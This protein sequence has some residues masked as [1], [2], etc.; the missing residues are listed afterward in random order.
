[1]HQ[2]SLPLFYTIWLYKTYST[3][4]L[5][6]FIAC[7]VVNEVFIQ[8]IAYTHVLVEI[9]S[10]TWT[11]TSKVLYAFVALQWGEWTEE[12]WKPV[13]VPQD[14]KFP[15]CCSP[16]IPCFVLHGLTSFSAFTPHGFQLFCDD[17]AKLLLSAANSSNIGVSLK[18]SSCI[19]ATYIH[20]Y[21]L[22]R[23]C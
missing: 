17:G 2:W 6:S 22:R 20:M 12:G 23:S 4:G 9:Y 7:I 14:V 15:G 21:P 16:K 8:Y 19:Y 1:M 3:S 18:L 10:H 5:K 13:L 11:N